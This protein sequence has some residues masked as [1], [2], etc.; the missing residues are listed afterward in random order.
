MTSWTCSV[1][2][3]PHPPFSFITPGELDR[4]ADHGVDKETVETM[5]APDLVNYTNE[6][7]LSSHLQVRP[8]LS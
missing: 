2:V 8:C 3:R 6:T 7:R 4:P 1:S 5:I